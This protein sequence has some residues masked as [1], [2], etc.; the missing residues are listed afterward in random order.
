M[1]TKVSRFSAIQESKEPYQCN[2]QGVRKKRN[3]ITQFEKNFNLYGNSILYGLE[4]TS[5][6]HPK[7]STLCID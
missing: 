3:K 7:V 6:G 5:K 4:M 1:V 2:S